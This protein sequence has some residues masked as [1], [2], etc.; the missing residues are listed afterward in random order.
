MS[1]IPA[2][3]SDRRLFFRSARERI[4][5]DTFGGENTYRFLKS[6][7]PDIDLLLNSGVFTGLDL[8]QEGVD[9]E[10]HVC[11]AM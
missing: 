10:W 2:D 8:A 4:I 6:R 7:N 9:T 5:R 11:H 1:R 3:A